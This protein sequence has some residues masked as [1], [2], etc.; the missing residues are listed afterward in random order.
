MKIGGRWHKNSVKTHRTFKLK[1]KSQKPK[2]KS[3][4]PKAKSQKPKAKSQKD[5][6]LSSHFLQLINAF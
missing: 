4:K 2:A 5:G 1:A 6:A 3:Q